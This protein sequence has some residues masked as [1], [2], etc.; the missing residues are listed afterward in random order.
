MFN[1]L[2]KKAPEFNIMPSD[3]YNITVVGVTHYQPA[4]AKVKDYYGEAK[5]ICENDNKFDTNAVKVMI[6]KYKVGYLSR[7]HALEHRAWLE[8][9]GH[10]EH[11]L[12]CNYRQHIARACTGLRLDL[13]Y[14]WSGD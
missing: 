1:W 9:Q 14:A 13:T 3:Y 11:T 6:G 4:I 10:K 2:K 7:L 5:L 12:I 8:N